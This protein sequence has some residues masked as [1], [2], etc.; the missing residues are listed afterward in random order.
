M[1]VQLLSCSTLTA[2]IAA[3]K[4]LP[5]SCRTAADLW[6]WDLWLRQ[7]CSTIVRSLW[8]DQTRSPPLRRTVLFDET[9]WYVGGGVQVRPPVY[10]RMVESTPGTLSSRTRH[11]K[12]PPARP[13]P[14]RAQQCHSRWC[15]P[16]VTATDCGGE[17]P[18]MNAPVCI[19]LF[20][21]PPQTSVLPVVAVTQA[22]GLGPS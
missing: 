7:K 21:Q 1:P 9:C 11:Q 14:W 22:G 19:K 15:R 6:W 3:V 20:M 8:R 17:T 2:K 12:H 10:N 4:G 16:A 5:Q 13:L 18:P